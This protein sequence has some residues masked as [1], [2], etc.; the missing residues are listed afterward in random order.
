[1]YC[2]HRVE[3]E[4]FHL[5]SVQGEPRAMRISR[6]SMESRTLEDLKSLSNDIS[7][8]EA[9]QESS[10]IVFITGREETIHFC[11]L[12]I[13]RIRC[14]NFQDVLRTSEYIKGGKEPVKM[15]LVQTNVFKS[16]K[17][18]LYSGRLILDNLNIFELLKL[19]EY[20]GVSSLSCLSLSYVSS[21]LTLSSVSD[22]LNQCIMVFKDDG[23]GKETLK[24][25]GN[26]VK[27]NLIA[28]RDSKRLKTIGKDGMIALIK[29]GVLQLDENEV[30]RLCIEWAR[31]Q[32]G[33]DE[34]VSP[35][36]WPEDQR[37]QIRLVLDG[38]VQCIRILNIDSAVFEE[39]VEPTGAVPI[40]QTVHR[41]RHS[42]NQDS[43]QPKPLHKTSKEVSPYPDNRRI[44]QDGSRGEEDTESRTNPTSKP[45]SRVE[46]TRAFPPSR[47][48]LRSRQEEHQRLRLAEDLSRLNPRVELDPRQHTY[49]RSNQ[50]NPTK[51]FHG[52]SILSAM[53][54]ES[55]ISYYEKVLNGWAGTP[56]QAWTVIFKGSEHAF[57]AQAFHRMCDGAAPSYVIVKA[58]TGQL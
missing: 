56:N 26:F 13:F 19:S 18:Y 51:L 52:S 23:A 10:D 53:G 12:S 42:T 35:K 22:L 47:Q 34:S 5:S 14:Q 6:E 24:M 27:E 40:E 31:L 3:L 36:H 50:Q 46:C 58:D 57:S 2:L 44:L 29:S 15:I 41:Y 45:G 21:S 32:V 38:L 49:Q 7:R 28:L 20:F 25:L 33:I 37:L 1:M 39:E 4:I 48:D 17:H 11:H 54:T 16:F 55:S 8:L 9:E 43:F 30:W